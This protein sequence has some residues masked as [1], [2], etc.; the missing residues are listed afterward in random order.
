MINHYPFYDESNAWMIASNMNWNNFIDILRIEGHPI[1]WFLIIMPFAKFNLF[2]PYSI[3]IINWIFCVLAVIVL[4]VKAPFDNRIKL[5]ITFS[6][7]FIYYYPVVARC[8][9]VGI[10]GLF[11]VASLYKKQLECPVLYACIIAI[12]AH[13]NLL[14]AISLSALG[15]IFIF[16]LCKQGS[17]DKYWC[18]AII[19]L[20]VLIWIFPYLYG[21][22]SEY[23]PKGGLYEL[24]KF[25]V[26]GTVSKFL[27]VSYILTLISVFIQSN[28]KFVKFFLLYTSFNM[29]VF[30]IFIYSGFAHHYIFLFINIII[31]MWIEYDAGKYKLYLLYPL[32]LCLFLIPLNDKLYYCFLPNDS[33]IAYKINNLSE[34]YTKTLY[35][36]FNQRTMSLLPYFDRKIKYIVLYDKKAV[37]PKDSY[38]L[39][40]NNTLEGYSKVIY[41]FPAAE[42]SSYY[43]EEIFR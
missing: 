41:K 36:R 30:F 9:S 15:L 3:L 26:I 8:Y 23:L 42:N 43:I 16:K 13:T 19:M 20:S 4:W 37:P 21:Y 6:S 2:Y 14:C 40:L 11:L 35:I 38:F 28:S 33:H 25:F 27:L 29:F 5:I 34:I 10:L 32:L 12:F 1:G 17:S 22:G 24:K 18:F 39:E 31:A 7:I